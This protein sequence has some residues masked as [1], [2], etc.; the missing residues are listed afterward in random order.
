MVSKE[1]YLRKI[2]KNK[3]SERQLLNQAPLAF[4]VSSDAFIT[5]ENR[6]RICIFLQVNACTRFSFL[7]KT[8]KISMFACTFN[9]F[10]FVMD[11]IP[12][13]GPVTD[14]FVCMLI[15][16]LCLVIMCKKQNNFELKMRLRG[17]INMQTKE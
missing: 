6:K 7:R 1:C 12:K 3:N 10:G 5:Y 11:L 14:S 4:S 16:P 9:L 15:S 17:L 2:I 13:W 8:K